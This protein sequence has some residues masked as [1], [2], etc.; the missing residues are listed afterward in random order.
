MSKLFFDHLVEFK[1]IDKKIKQVAQTGVER[2][3]LWVLVDEIVHHKVMGCILD[4][5]A[6]GDHEEFL[7]IFHKSPHDTELIFSYLKTKVGEDVEQVLK[8]EIDKLSQ[9][10]VRDLKLN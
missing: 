3:E 6:K 1:E 5:L 9:D 8:D 2:E 4:K 10:L 7:H